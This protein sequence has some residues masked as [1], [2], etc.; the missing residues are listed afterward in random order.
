MTHEIVPVHLAIQAM[1]DNG[2]KN[3]A[4]AIAEL[5]DNAI[6]AG[7]SSVELLCAGKKVQSGQR[8]F[9][10]L[11]QV[12]VLDNGSGMD[13]ETLSMAL[14][15]G[16]GKYLD[17]DKHTGIGRYGMGL[18]SSSISQCRRV[19]VWTWTNGIEN[20]FYSYL[21][22]DEIKQDKLKS[23]P[24]PKNKKV[25]KIW[26]KVSNRIGAT[27]TLIVWSKID[28]CIWK[29]PTAVIRNSELLIGRMYRK[30]IS[31]KSVSIRMV[32][33]DMDNRHDLTEQYALPNDPVYL[34][35]KTSCPQ[36]FDE[37]AMFELYSRDPYP[38]TYNGK[39][40][41]VIVTYTYAKEE[42]RSSQRW[43]GDPGR[44]P[45]GKHASKNLGVSI[46]RADRELD[47]D[48]AI[49]NSYDPTE[50]WWG[51]EI[52]FPPA[53]D[54]IFGVTNNKQSARYLSDVLNQDFDE[55]CKRD[56]ISPT[57]MLVRMKEDGD[58]HVYLIELGQSIKNRLGVIR[59]LLKAQT[60][61]SKAQIRGA[62][63]NAENIATN[64]TKERQQSGHFGQSDKDE[65]AP[66]EERKAK[67]KEALEE[68]GNSQD[69]IDSIIGSTFKSERTLKY[70]FNHV[71]I[72]S[73]AFFT[74]KPKGGELI[75]SLNT[76]HPAYD[77]LFELLEDDEEADDVEVLRNHL[78]KAREALKLIFMAWAR[79][80]DE[81]PDGPSRVQAQ[82]IR[83]DWGTIARGFLSG[84]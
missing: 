84:E 60:K 46:M 38:V 36:P 22:L 37:T 79:Y 52:E 77:K 53:L 20:A 17:P 48:T 9:N 80:E 63:D 35:D 5:I 4:Y 55:F 51:I 11:D 34:I 31:N 8:I 71:D 44:R 54:D 47:L 70:I 50:R 28:R 29:R 75:I 3:A 12:A 26:Q 32:A 42:A 16:N 43:G 6:Q 62:G 23:V 59:R 1:R 30:F 68:M 83:F 21:D 7:A 69:T 74:V 76:N 13:S 56:D 61:G 58:T 40:H 39:V 57:E 25:P 67:I 19:D 82:Q 66:V 10:C 2:Y 24:E 65:N 81:Q 27:G 45:H 49:V 41:E 15:F 64:A 33:F 73:P 18:P 14:Q 78:I 72:E